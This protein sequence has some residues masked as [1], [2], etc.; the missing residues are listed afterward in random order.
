MLLRQCLDAGEIARALADERRRSRALEGLA[1]LAL[2]IN[3]ADSLDEILQVAAQEAREIIGAHQAAASLNHD[4]LDSNDPAADA[5]SLSEKHAQALVYVSDMGRE[6]WFSSLV[7][8]LNQPMR[9][10]QAELECDLRRGDESASDRALIEPVASAPGAA[11]GLEWGLDWQKAHDTCETHRHPQALEG[12]VTPLE[13]ATLRRMASLRE[14][15][16]FREVATPLEIA[17]LREVEAARKPQMLRGL[18]MRGWLAAPLTSRNGAYGRNLGL[19]QLSDK[20]EGEFTERDEVELAQIAL[21]VSIAVENRLYWRRE[22]KRREAAE[23]AAR[24]NDEFIAMTS[25]R[26]RAQLNT[27]LGWSW[28]LRRQAENMEDVTRAAEIIER[29]ARTQAGIVEDLLDASRKG[30]VKWKERETG[31][32]GDGA[33]ERRGDGEIE[34]GGDFSWNPAVA[35]SPCRPIA[36]SLRP[37]VHYSPNPTSRGVAAGGGC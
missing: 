32:H 34:G 18:D 21:M 23:N 2:V 8:R 16:G 5:K 36:P 33:T 37:P 13:V 24:A 28:V 12:V 14:I 4:A 30:A 27:L 22:Q 19:I 9:L 29:A 11:L 10:T 17:C 20:Y 25:H 31:E 15:A 35:L 6:T 7:C 26:L 3:S 1:R